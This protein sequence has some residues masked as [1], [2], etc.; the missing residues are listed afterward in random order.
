[1]IEQTL[2]GVALF[3]CGFIVGRKVERDI[4]EYSLKQAGIELVDK[5]DLQ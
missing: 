1:M 2:L 4:T 3:V 5:E